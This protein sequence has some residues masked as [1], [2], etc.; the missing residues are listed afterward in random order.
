MS[1]CVYSLIP[2]QSSLVW[3]VLNVLKDFDSHPQTKRR[4]TYRLKD[5]SRAATGDSSEKLNP[6]L[7]MYCQENR[8]IQFKS[9][10]KNPLQ[11]CAACTHRQH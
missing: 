6:P 3:D 4:R 5:S 1:S 2:I 11:L 9:D 8:V 7:R 10:Q